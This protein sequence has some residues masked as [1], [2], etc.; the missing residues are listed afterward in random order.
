MELCDDCIKILLNDLPEEAIAVL[1]KIELFNELSERDLVRKLSL[2]HKLLKQILYELEAKLLLSYKS[3][4]KNKAYQLT[5][6]GT[7]LLRLE[8]KEAEVNLDLTKRE[9]ADELSKKKIKPD[10]KK[11]KETEENKIKDGE[12]NEEDKLNDKEKDD[13]E[14]EKENEFDEAKENLVWDFK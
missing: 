3:Y 6:N 10:E 11:E 4:G 9:T 14:D 13:L 12:Q 2:H 8:N 1:N 7:R 5:K